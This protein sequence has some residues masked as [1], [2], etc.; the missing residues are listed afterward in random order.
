MITKK[1]NC[2][3][4]HGCPSN[5]K[6][7]MNPETRTYDKHWIPWIKKELLLRNIKVD[8]PLMPTP[9]EPEYE[10]WKK[11]MGKL[12]VNKNS[13]LIGHSCGGTFLIRWL[14]ETKKKVKKLILVSPGKVGKARSRF[15]ANL[16]GDKIVKNLKKYVHDEIVLFTSNNDIKEHIEG[17]YEYE[18]ELP[19]KIIFLKNKGH[20]T[21]GDMGTE[22][23]PELLKEII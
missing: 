9:W 12:D 4:L 22:E 1:T 7:A 15:T 8:A 16:Y 17:A 20:F 18:K 21:Q 23:F 13:T 11:I 10:E 14:D 6:K 5:A 2:F 19:A 3:I